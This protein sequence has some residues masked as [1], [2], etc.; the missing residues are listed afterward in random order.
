MRLYILL[1]VIVIFT[2][3][4][5]GTLKIKQVINDRK[6]VLS[7]KE[8]E[9]NFLRIQIPIIFELENSYKSNIQIYSLSYVYD[10]GK[11]GLVSPYYEVIKNKDIKQS[12]SLKKEIESEKSITY[13]IYSQHLIKEDSISQLYLSKYKNIIEGEFDSIMDFKTFRKENKEYCDYMIKNDLIKIKYKIKD[14]MKIK[15]IPVKF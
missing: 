5:K 7:Y 10:L 4:K 15:K 12:F 13:M 9:S 1:F 6:V 14:K 11:K 3:C 8:N 2:S